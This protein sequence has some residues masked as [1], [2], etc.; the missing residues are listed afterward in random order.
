MS[1]SSRVSHSGSERWSSC[2]VFPLALPMSCSL[3]RF[4]TR[5]SIFFMDSFRCLSRLS[6]LFLSF[7]FLLLAFDCMV[8]LSLLSS[9]SPIP[10]IS[11]LVFPS[12]SVRPGM[13][14]TLSLQGRF[15]SLAAPNPGSGPALAIGK[16]YPRPERSVGVKHQVEAPNR[17]KRGY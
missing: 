11:Y 2:C 15:P 8:S 17:C 5:C 14:C 10:V 7:S 12:F 16:T 3:P 9:S 13:V 6:S 1:V 4:T